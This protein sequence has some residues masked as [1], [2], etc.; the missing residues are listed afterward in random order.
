MMAATSAMFWGLGLACVIGGA[1]AGNAVGSAQ[2]LTRSALTQLD[3]PD[4]RAA[5]PL[6]TRKPLP[7]HYPLVTRQG[8][9]PVAALATRGLYS[10]ARYRPIMPVE[11]DFAFE[12]G[13]GPGLAAMVPPVE[14]AASLEHSAPALDQTEVAVEH[15]GS[16]L[17][18]VKAT[19][20]MQ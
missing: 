17:V 10:Q 6:P 8:T 12:E 7:D 2:P 20:A 11:S 19:L 5:P 18:D 4:D 9:V 13:P 1:A 3:E 16:K 15:G 14:P